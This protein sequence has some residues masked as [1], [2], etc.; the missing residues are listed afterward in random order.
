M[1]V[2]LAFDIE[3]DLELVVI[4]DLDFEI[5]IDLEFL[6]SLQTGARRDNEHP[7]NFLPGKIGTA[8]VAAIVIL[9][10]SS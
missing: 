7:D 1:G 8:N 9:D 2:T 6:E 4:P 3:M 5:E 10:H